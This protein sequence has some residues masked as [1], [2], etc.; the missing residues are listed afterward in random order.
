MRSRDGFGS[1]QL[2]YEDE[3]HPLRAKS[4]EREFGIGVWTRTGAAVLFV[5]A[6]SAGAYVSPTLTN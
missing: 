4:Y 3:S 5:D 1:L 6:G 2:V